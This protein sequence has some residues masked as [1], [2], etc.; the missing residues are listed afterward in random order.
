MKVFISWSGPQSHALARIVYDWLPMVLPFVEPWLSS[1]D[2]GKGQ[3]WATDIAQRLE[4]SSCCIVCVTPGVARQPWV[5]FEAGA[6]SKIIQSSQ[7]SPLLFGVSG[8]DLDNLPLAMFQW[9]TFQK[10][11]VC[12]L[13]RSMN[14]A[15][16]YRIPHTEL[17]KRLDYTWDQVSKKT[18]NVE[19]S[20]LPSTEDTLQ[21]NR[22]GT[23]GLALSLQESEILALIARE[24]DGSRWMSEFGVSLECDQSRA[25]IRRHLNHLVR[26]RLLEEYVDDD[27]ERSYQLTETG[28]DWVVDHSLD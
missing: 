12:K 23:A 22:G 3:R 15:S 21:D 26:L 28:F 1:E 19:P 16:E 4:E 10:D 7:V 13:L 25:R 24:Y 8:A 11:D 27:G 14:E 9:T 2:I 20:S 5:N 17:I 6:I 18:E